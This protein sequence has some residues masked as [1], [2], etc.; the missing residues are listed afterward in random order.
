MPI[1]NSYSTD[2]FTRLEEWYTNV[3]R[4]TLLNAYL[5]QPLSSSLSNTSPYIFGAYGTDNRFESSD[6]LSRW[7][8]IDQRFKAKGIRI[9]GFSTDC[10]SRDFHSM[11]TSL[12]FFA[13]FA[14]GD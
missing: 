7:Y 1:L 8:Q 5:I 2:S 3:P 10:D 12:G 14:Y 13:N 6:V 4:A 9:L 11:R